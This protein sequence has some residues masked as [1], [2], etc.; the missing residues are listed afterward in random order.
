MP[1]CRYVLRQELN[2]GDLCRTQGLRLFAPEPFVLGF[3]TRLF[4]QRLF[5]LPLE[6]TC[7]QTVLRLHSSVLPTCPLGLIARAFD[8]VLPLPIKRISFADKIAG[9]PQASFQ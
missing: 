8:T 5:P 6:R 1:E 3:N 7:N 9:S 4:C 2:R